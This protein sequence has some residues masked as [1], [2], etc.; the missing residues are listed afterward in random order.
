MFKRLPIYFFSLTA[1]LTQE[2][3]KSIHQIEL[4]YNNTYYLEPAFKPSTG[5]AGP[6]QTRSKT[7]TKTVFGYHI[8]RRVESRCKD[9]ETGEVVEC[10]E[11]SS[12]LE[13]A[14]EDKPPWMASH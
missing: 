1:G 13:G 3:P 2:I 6:L 5:P 14:T 11:S 4:E 7:L 9:T 8:I 12:A 10:Q